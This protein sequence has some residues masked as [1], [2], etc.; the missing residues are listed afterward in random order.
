MGMSRNNQ[1]RYANWMS[2]SPEQKEKRTTQAFARQHA[3]DAIKAI[4]KIKLKPPLTARVIHDANRNIFNNY[5]VV[6]QT[7]GLGSDPS[8][9]YVRLEIKF[10]KFVQQFLNFVDA[11]VKLLDG[12]MTTNFLLTYEIIQA[13]NIVHVM[14]EK[15]GRVVMLAKLGHFDE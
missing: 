2:L 8:D 4:A 6:R 14:P 7:D 10:S 12:N 5:A 9:I 1:R 3:G 15:L 13:Y 11:Q